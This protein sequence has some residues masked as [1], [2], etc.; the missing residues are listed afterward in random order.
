M[1]YDFRP[2]TT[3]LLVNVPHAGLEVPGEIAAQLSS[4]AADLPD[5]D[6][7]VHR[8]V[9][10]CAA[11]QEAS[12]MCAR[13]SR[14]VIDLN[15]GADD[16]PLYSGATTALVPTVTFDGD[17][18]YAGEAPDAGEVAQRVQRYWRP[19]HDRLG[20]ELEA[21]RQRHGFAVLFD[22][23]SIRGRVPRLFDGPLPD[24]NLGTYEERSCSPALQEVVAE[25]IA[26]AEGFSSVVN[27]RFKGGYIT[28]HYGRPD[29]GIHALQIEIAQGCYM[30]EHN[31]R[32]FEPARASPL[33]SLLDRL[34]TLLSRWRPA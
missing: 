3:P 15:R 31:P 11:E 16:K 9:E 2:G 32:E 8:L 4:R 14:Y 18:V 28:R 27:G 6:W 12:L 26:G 30:D 21:L 25:M 24:L 33:V 1:L 34:I 17:P 7:H 29:A 19:Y 23:H 10:G 22:V 13:Y 5:T 20:R